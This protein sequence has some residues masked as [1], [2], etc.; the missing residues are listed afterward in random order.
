MKEA[1]ASGLVGEHNNKNLKNKKIKKLKKKR[2]GRRM[3]KDSI[4]ISS[5]KKPHYGG[6]YSHHRDGWKEKT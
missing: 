5:P 2:G 4:Y 3:E 1:G 6:G